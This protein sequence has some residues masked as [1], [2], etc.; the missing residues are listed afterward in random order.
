MDPWTSK[1][2][3]AKQDRGKPATSISITESTVLVEL[4]YWLL[5][6]EDTDGFRE[7]LPQTTQEKGY[8]FLNHSFLFCF[9]FVGEQYK[10]DTADDSIL[11]MKEKIQTNAPTDIGFETFKDNPFSTVNCYM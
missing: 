5:K 4:V 1:T 9:V 3:N 8:K 11:F 2:N 7:I 10:N 6:V